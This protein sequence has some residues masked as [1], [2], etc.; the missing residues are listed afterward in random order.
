MLA[1]PLRLA[2]RCAPSLRP[3]VLLEPTDGRRLR[4]EPCDGKNMPPGAVEA[5]YLCSGHKLY[6]ARAWKDDKLIIG[7]VRIRRQLP[8]F[9]SVFL[10]TLSVAHFQTWVRQR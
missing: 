1:G 6:V 2:E 4:W 8:S 9:G 10:R 3:Q 7:H 5:G